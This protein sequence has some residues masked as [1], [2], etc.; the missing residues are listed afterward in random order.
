MLTKS[1]P[2]LVTLYNALDTYTEKYGFYSVASLMIKYNLLINSLDLFVNCSKEEEEL[3]RFELNKATN[4]VQD[5]YR[6]TSR[7]ERTNPRGQ[8]ASII[9]L[10]GN[11][12]FIY[13]SEFYQQRY[14]ESGKEAESSVIRISQERASAIEDHQFYMYAIT[15]EMEPLVYLQTIPLMDLID[16]R[17]QLR[18]ESGPIGHPVLLHNH[19][20]IARGAGEA[21]FVKDRLGNI[22]GVI[23]NNKSGHYCP[24]S[25]TLSTVKKAFARQLGISDD[26]VV[27]IAVEED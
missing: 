11:T 25:W 5:H 1:S 22:K 10:D 13:D 14:V 9:D 4:L 8:R 3:F 26:Y 27:T 20:L 21:T 2:I 17:K 16:G 24:P 15:G 6:N 12:A 18:N 23:A 19:N 7:T